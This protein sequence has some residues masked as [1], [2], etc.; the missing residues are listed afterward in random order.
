MTVSVLRGI[1][2]SMF[3]RLCWRAPRTEILVIGMHELESD[4]LPLCGR[5]PRKVGKWGCAALLR[6]LFVNSR[7]R[8][9][10]YSENARTVRNIRM[11]CRKRGSEVRHLNDRTKGRAELE[12]MGGVDRDFVDGSIFGFVGCGRHLRC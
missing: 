6:I 10:G 7:D 11:G 9:R 3:L 1:S 5:V 4:D 2:T 8:Q 12:R